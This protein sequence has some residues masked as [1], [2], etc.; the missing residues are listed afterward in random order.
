MCN[1]TSYTG[2]TNIIRKRT[3]NHISS[4]RNGSGSNIFDNHVYN[5]GLRNNC[6]KPPFFKLCVFMCV[7]N[8][9]KLLPTERW[10]HSK[11]FDTLN[12]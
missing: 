9:S 11:G 7:S 2:K 4:C 3:N 6:L 10:L 12:S 1:V 5:C 8:E